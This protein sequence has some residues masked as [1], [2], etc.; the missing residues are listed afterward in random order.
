MERLEPSIRRDGGTPAIGME[1]YIHT[2]LVRTYLVRIYRYNYEYL[3][4]KEGGL[5]ASEL[6]I[7]YLLYL[8]YHNFSDILAV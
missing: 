4:K 6:T 7:Y 1:L 3:G 8:G 5:S 2:I